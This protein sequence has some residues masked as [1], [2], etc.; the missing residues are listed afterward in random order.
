M[1]YTNKKIR[2]ADE[3]SRAFSF[4]VVQF[5]RSGVTYFSKTVI[6]I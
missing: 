1:Y 4:N 5:L 6:Q 3:R 2:N